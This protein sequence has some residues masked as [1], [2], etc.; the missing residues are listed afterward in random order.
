MMVDH[1]ILEDAKAAGFYVDEFGLV[2]ADGRFDGTY[3]GD[4][5]EAFA[6]LRED[7]VR[8]DGEAVIDLI[9]TAIE[10][11]ELKY[12]ERALEKLREISLPQ[13]PVAWRGVNSGTLY[14]SRESVEKYF[15]GNEQLEP[16]YA[17]KQDSRR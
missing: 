10:C 4:E 9:E 5:L 2:F 11:G 16:L 15:E 3:I 13:A 12:A 14:P 8:G 7:R 6:R 1:T 17:G